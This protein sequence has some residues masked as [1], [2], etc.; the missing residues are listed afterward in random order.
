M[1]PSSGSYGQ[2]PPSARSERSDV[3]ATAAGVLAIAV[4]SGAQ[5]LVFLSEFGVNAR[6]DA[7]FAA[8]AIYVL[9]VL[10][11]Q[12]LRTG[13]VP[14]VS[15]LYA[16][17]RRSE[18]LLL[19]CGVG[20]VLA[21][22]VAI[23]AEP[24]AG[25]IG[26]SLGKEANGVARDALRLL[27]PSMALQLAAAAFAVLA[28]IDGRMRRIA[29]AYAAGAL[30][31][32]IAFLLLL[33][34]LDELALPAGVIF[35][36]SVL[37]VLLLPVVSLG[38]QRAVRWPGLPRGLGR[39]CASVV[40]PFALMAA[41]PITLAMVTSAKPGEI[42]V[43]AYAYTFCSY[44]PGFTSVAIGMN[45]VVALAKDPSEVRARF[46]ARL[47]KRLVVSLVAAVVLIAVAAFAGPPVFELLA[48]AGR[49]EIDADRLRDFTLALAPWTLAAQ[50]YFLT[51]PA[52]YAA[53]VVSRFALF[54]PLALLAFLAAS[55]VARG[56]WGID[57]LVVALGVAPIV[58][59]AVALAVLPRRAAAPQAA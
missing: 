12:F 26:P 27:A 19:A 33:G 10:F 49:T 9:V 43:L 58:L 57:G 28:G 29:F 21:L 6:T 54:L 7:V 20:V 30:A 52:L 42:T 31:G 3:V 38:D 41:Y 32:L 35:G 1:S 14:L 45:D 39:V 40:P 56:A 2:S 44:I 48:P 36:S 16:P 46:L 55:F 50:L 15:G 13:A 51:L 23:L 22:L 59:S 37:F 11:G 47:P 53:H 8:Y 25:L 18:F 24:I 5:A 17:L 4:G 34:P